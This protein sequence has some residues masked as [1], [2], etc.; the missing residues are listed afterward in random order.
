MLILRT[1][2]QKADPRIEFFRVWL[3][4]EILGVSGE[5]TS[6]GYVRYF[7]HRL[8]FGG[9]SYD[10]LADIIYSI[11]FQGELSRKSVF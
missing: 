7:S 1:Y 11:L 3:K 6:V 9:Q 5:D 2:G 10:G 8:A 4:V